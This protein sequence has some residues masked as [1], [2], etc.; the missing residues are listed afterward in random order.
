M[1]LVSTSFKYNFQFRLLQTLTFCIKGRALISSE[2]RQH[3]GALLNAVKWGIPALTIV[4]A[5]TAASSSKSSSISSLQNQDGQLAF[6]E[7]EVV[8]E[9]E[10]NESPKPV[11]KKAGHPTKMPVDRDNG[12][13]P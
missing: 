3:D 4:S 2:I 5:V 7:T 13:P 8:L 12:P 1:L 11:K 10:Q 9:A 6:K